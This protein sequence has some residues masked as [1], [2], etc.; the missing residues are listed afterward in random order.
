MYLKVFKWSQSIGEQAVRILSPF[1]S[2]HQVRERRVEWPECLDICIYTF[3]LW[4]LLQPSSEFLKLEHAEV[5][6]LVPVWE[7]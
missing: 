7:T 1:S 4:V 5:L 3:L 2:P 6:Y